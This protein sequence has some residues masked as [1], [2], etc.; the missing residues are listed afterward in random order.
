MFSIVIP[1]YNKVH[2]IERTLRSVFNQTFPDFEVIVVNDGS[3]DDGVNFITENF[4]DKRLV[5]VNQEN[6]GVTVARNKGASVAKFNYIAFLDG[7]DTW[8]SKYLETASEAVSKFPESGMICLAGYYAEKE[9]EILDIRL[10]KKYKGKILKVNYFE[11]PHV[12]SHTSATIVSAE[13]FNSVKGF[14]KGMGANEDFALFF[15]LALKREVV[16]IGIPLSTYFGGVDGQLTSSNDKQRHL[17][18]GV[19]NRINYA[20][21]IWM[22]TPNPRNELYPIFIRYEIR[23]TILDSIKIGDFDKVNFYGTMLSKDVL[24]LFPKYEFDFYTKSGFSKFKLLYIN[25]TKVLWRMK[26]LPRVGE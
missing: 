10:A 7:D 1:L 23:H 26:G 6:Q 11:N 12:F 9:G 24:S 15:A 20:H 4:K 18:M 25:F 2:T 19:I 14:Q 21:K 13:A 8:E 5:I 17:L 3:I 22:E 16:Y